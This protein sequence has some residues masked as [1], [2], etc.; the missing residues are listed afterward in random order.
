MSRSHTGTGSRPPSDPP[1]PRDERRELDLYDLIEMIWSQRGM[2][3]A[4]FLVLFVAGAAASFLLLNKTYE[5]RARLLVLLDDEDLTPGAAGSG[6]G[7][8][9][10]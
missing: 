2:I 5:A 7:F 3:I 8:I 9:I 6:D 1:H 4:V 10:E